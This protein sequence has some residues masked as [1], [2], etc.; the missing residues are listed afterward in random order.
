MTYSKSIFATQPG[1]KVNEFSRKPHALEE[2]PPARVSAAS[3]EKATWGLLRVQGSHGGWSTECAPQ[4]G[5][6]WGALLKT[7][8][9]KRS[10]LPFP[11]SQKPH[12]CQEMAEK[13][14]SSST[15]A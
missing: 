12:L 6:G 5:A 1:R 14:K 4:P 13:V 7:K 3:A 8:K 11:F 15:L 2:Q 10:N 9:K